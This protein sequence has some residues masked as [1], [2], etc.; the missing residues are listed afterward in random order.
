MKVGGDGFDLSGSEAR[1]EQ[2]ILEKCADKGM[3]V[4]ERSR[5]GIRDNNIISC[6]IEIA[7]KDESVAVIRDSGLARLEIGIALYNKK[8][9]F[10]PPSADVE[11]VVM[12][13]VATAFLEGAGSTLKLSSSFRYVQ[14]LQASE[15]NGMIT[16][17]F[18]D[19]LSEVKLKDPLLYDRDG[20][21]PW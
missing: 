11:T 13:D 16:V 14:G 1:S 6:Q 12:A 2:D 7:V 20:K 5:A 10:K 19:T 4:G 3:S 21:F 17:P 8:L 15:R 18:E 9:T